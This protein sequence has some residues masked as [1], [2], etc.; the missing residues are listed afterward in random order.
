MLWQACQIAFGQPLELLHHLLSLVHRVKALDP[1]HDFHLHLQGQHVAKRLVLRINQPSAVH[2]DSA[3]HE[4]DLSAARRLLYPLVSTNPRLA[5]GPFSKGEKS[6]P[7]GG[8]PR[9]SSRVQS[10][11]VMSL[12]QSSSPNTSVKSHAY[13]MWAHSTLFS[14]TGQDGEFAAIVG[15]LL[16]TH[17]HVVRHA[18]DAIPPP[19]GQGMPARPVQAMHP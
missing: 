18:Q 4:S 17:R 19:D 15:V 16:C 5:P 13:S 1:K 14:C 11:H 6:V 2:D 3:K 10:P 7:M 9:V 12:Y 8:T